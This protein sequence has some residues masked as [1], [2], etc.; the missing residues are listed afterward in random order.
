LSVF[1]FG[2]DIGVDEKV[3]D[4]IRIAKFSYLYTTAVDLEIS[5]LINAPPAT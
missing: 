4:W 3:L 2:L 1:G 5:K